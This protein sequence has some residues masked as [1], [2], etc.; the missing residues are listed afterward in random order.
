MRRGNGVGEGPRRERM[1]MWG[2]WLEGVGRG[3][4]TWI[5][6]RGWGEQYEGKRSRV[7]R[8][9]GEKGV[10]RLG[11]REDMKDM[12]VKIGGD[13]EGIERYGKRVEGYG[14]TEDG[15]GD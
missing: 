15:S 12:V 6:W 2:I 5:R 10:A 7:G 4:E 13:W 8:D 11:D 3:R 1:R 9:G 14:A